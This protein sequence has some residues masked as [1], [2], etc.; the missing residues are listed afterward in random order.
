MEDAILP[1]TVIRGI[2]AAAMGVVILAAL[3]QRPAA[4]AQKAPGL[5]LD[6]GKE[7]FQT[8]CL[9][10]HGPGGEGQ[11]KA[12]L[13]FEPPATFPDFTDC[14]GS[15][16]ERELD[17]KATIHGGGHARG[18][19]EIMPSFA[20]ALTSEQI[21][22]V[23]DYLRTL[24][25]DS[26]W[27]RGE[28]NLPRPLVTEKAFPE[29][30][31]VLTVS[32]HATGAP[33]LSSELVYERRFGAKDQIEAALPLALQHLDSGGWSGGVGDI[34]LGYKRVLAHSWQGGSILSVQGE[35]QLPTGS[36][37][38]GFGSG[39]T[40]FETFAAFG[41]ILPRRSFVQF[42]GG[43]EL[44]LYGEDVSKAVFWRT[45]VGKSWEEN[46]GLGRAWT[47]MVEFLAD[48][49]LGS[50]D[51]TH[52]DILPQVQVTLSRRQHIRADLGVRFPLNDVSQ[53]NTEVVF[54]VL[55]DW[56]DGGLREGW[57]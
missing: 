56:F 33:A 2:L 20:E 15:T 13:G 43:A 11:P 32:A 37:S 51:K 41:Q 57:K 18:F 7:I 21:D 42:Q 50:G 38:K 5:K 10:C 39:V 40:V 24:C 53:R 55:W 22:K 4:A 54:Y 45:A 47:P 35:F 49:E 44:P 34:V 12:M 6:T 28:L 26:R 14:S 8:A 3:C 25:P 30:E 31:A 1:G 48:R 27:P 52:W 46:G 29:D 9:A 17:W 16:R 36:Q 19:S 23:A